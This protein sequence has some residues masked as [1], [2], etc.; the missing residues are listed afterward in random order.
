MHGTLVDVRDHLVI[1]SKNL[2]AFILEEDEEHV[3]FLSQICYNFFGD[4][5]SQYEAEARKD[6]HELI[7]LAQRAGALLQCGKHIWE[8]QPSSIPILF[9]QLSSDFSLRL[10]H[11]LSQMY[12]FGHSAT[13]P[14]NAFFPVWTLVLLHGG[15]E[16]RGS[17][18]SGRVPEILCSVP[19][20]SQDFVGFASLDSDTLQ[21]L[22]RH[23]LR[24]LPSSY[25][26]L[27]LFY[28]PEIC[29]IPAHFYSPSLPYFILSLFFCS[30]F[31]RVKR[32]I[33][34]KYTDFI[35]HLEA[36]VL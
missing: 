24:Y 13:E 4:V 14:L 30:H 22:E 35:D 17:R 5:M 23:L 19:L 27:F 18:W 11:V 20:H 9:F 7:G 26:P 25:T 31:N 1:R 3:G 36:E 8:T 12:S 2:I 33:Q 28:L 34:E 15:W 16:I 21:G 29:S 32:R 10:L 6:Q